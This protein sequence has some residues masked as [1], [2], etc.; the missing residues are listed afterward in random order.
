MDVQSQGG[1]QGEWDRRWKSSEKADE[2]GFAEYR[3][4][5]LDKGEVMRFILVIV[6]VPRAQ[7]LSDANRFDRQRDAL[8]RHPRH[9]T[10]HKLLDGIESDRL[11]Q[12][13]GLARHPPDPS[14]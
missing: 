9:K 11:D 10:D 12:V 1:E 14:G 8:R 13:T 3:S 2:A 4:E 5:Y 6:M 7:L